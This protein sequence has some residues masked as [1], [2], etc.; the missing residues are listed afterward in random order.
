MSEIW[1][2]AEKRGTQIHSSTYELLGKA[3]ELAWKRGSSVALALLIQERPTE[4]TF[5]NL[6]R[7]GADRVMVA[8]DKSFER[9]DFGPYIRVLK[10]MVSQRPPEVILAPATT[11][12]R[13]YMPG[14][15]ALLGTGLTADCT[16]LDIEEG[17]GNPHSRLHRAGYR[18]G[19]R[20]PAPDQTGDRRQYNG[21][22]KDPKAQAPDGDSETEDLL[23][24]R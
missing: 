20:Q 3:R 14:L 8:V 23:P 6:F 21:D 22:H 2:I 24:A 18:R 11:S 9:F 5:R 7:G 15:A 4:E 17:T 12:G 1:V 19:N 16:G 13:T 10:E